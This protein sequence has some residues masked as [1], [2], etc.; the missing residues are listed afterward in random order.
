MKTSLANIVLLN[1]LFSIF[2][3]SANSKTFDELNNQVSTAQRVQVNS[4]SKKITI[5]LVALGAVTPSK[6]FTANSSMPAVS[7]IMRDAYKRESDMKEKVFI[8]TVISAL[9]I[10]MNVSNDITY[11]EYKRSEKL[12]FSGIFTVILLIFITLAIF[13]TKLLRK[14]EKPVN[15]IISEFSISRIIYFVFIYFNTGTLF[16]IGIANEAIPTLSLSL[17]LLFIILSFT[18]LFNSI[19]ERMYNTAVDTFKRNNFN[20]NINNKSVSKIKFSKS[21]INAQFTIISLFNLSI[22]LIPAWQNLYFQ[23]IAVELLIIQMLS[24]MVFI[25][26]SASGL[27]VDNSHIL[28]SLLRLRFNKS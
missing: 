14:K 19:L 11:E 20:E 24:S 5:D 16:S 27:I 17:V 12:R 18:V 3:V 6:P 22:L 23:N 25:G 7:E 28:N 13:N 4:K 26:K 21:I 10:H 8:D 15:S 1:V 9:P 2:S